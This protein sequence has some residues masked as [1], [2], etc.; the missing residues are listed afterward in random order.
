MNRGQWVDEL[1]RLADQVAQA[2]ERL[3]HL[4]TRMPLN[5]E[6]RSLNYEEDIQ[7]FKA[8]YN[9]AV[10]RALAAGALDDDD[11]ADLDLPLQM[12]T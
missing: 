9:T 11:L 7:Q 4:A 6:A 10:A 12:P 8:D 2:E 1:R 3:D 5:V